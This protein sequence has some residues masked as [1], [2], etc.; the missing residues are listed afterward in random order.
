MLPDASSAISEDDRDIGE[1]LADAGHFLGRHLKLAELEDLHV[2][3]RREVGGE[4]FDKRARQGEELKTLLLREPLRHLLDRIPA[5][6]DVGERRKVLQLLRDFGKGVVA[7]VWDER[8]S[9]GGSDESLF[10]LSLSHFRPLNSAIPSR[11][12]SALRSRFM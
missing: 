9:S 11:F 6:L 2:L 10:S 8:E 4:P 3:P 7:E 1:G 5:Q 12:V